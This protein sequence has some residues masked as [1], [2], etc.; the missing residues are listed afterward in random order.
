M[1]FNFKAINL[2][3]AAIGSLGWII[4]NND[5]IFK[6]MVIVMLLMLLLQ[7]VQK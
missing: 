3:L 6:V 5:T 2:T 4:T 1:E 7:D